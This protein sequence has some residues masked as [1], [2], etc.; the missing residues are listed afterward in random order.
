[1]IEGFPAEQTLPLLVYTDSYRVRGLIRTRRRR[2]SDV[3]NEPDA[4]FLVVED[5][6]FEEFGSGALLHRA[7][8]AQVNLSAVLFAVS[9]EPVDPQP[10]LR[11]IKVSR[12][13]LISLPPFTIVGHIHLVPE[14]DLRVALHE[15]K[16]R[17]LPVTD[18]TYWSDYLDEGRTEVPM[19][20]FNHARA[21]IL[22]PYDGPRDAT[23]IPASP[24]TSA[25]APAPTPA[26]PPTSAAPA[27]APTPTAPIDP[28]ASDRGRDAGG[29]PG[30]S[31][32]DPERGPQPA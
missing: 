22:A 14:P 26:A 1:V 18:V 21:Q 5:V 29:P 6:V 7:N 8:Y 32:F 2:L 4:A 30:G 15:L 31:A 16:N 9:N 3:L 19:V 28:P 12:Q 25:Q 20:A 13:A 11:Q 10:E 23:P 24:P 17:F 27:P